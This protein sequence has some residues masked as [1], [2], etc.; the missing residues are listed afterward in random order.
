MR[1]RSTDANRLFSSSFFYLLALSLLVLLSRTSKE[2]SA[3][4]PEI[5]CELDSN[6]DSN[7]ENSIVTKCRAEWQ[8]TWA[9]IAPRASNPKKFSLLSGL[10]DV[11]EQ[12]EI[13]FNMT[14]V[15]GRSVFGFAVTI[16]PKCSSQV[17]CDATKTSITLQTPEAD[18][19]FTSKACSVQ[20][21]ARK[22]AF[23][24]PLNRNDR[25]VFSEVTSTLRCE[26]T[27]KPCSGSSMLVSV[28]FEAELA[29]PLK[30][31]SPPMSPVSPNAPP[32]PPSPPMPPGAFAPGGHGRKFFQILLVLVAI[33]CSLGYALALAVTRGRWSGFTE[34]CMRGDGKGR[35][36]CGLLFFWWWPR[37]WTEEDE[38]CLDAY[39]ED[40]EDDDEE[41]GRRRLLDGSDNGSSSSEEDEE[42]ESE[43]EEE[44][45]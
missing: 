10:A 9:P 26:N 17:G 4:V 44:D 25:E 38:R 15:K 24:A 27:L 33:Y 23:D 37:F 30:P 13:P 2:A 41:T 40:D 22:C 5:R 29:A 34:P 20:E 14:N 16:Q 32:P 12:R 31:P 42:E 43:E 28:D 11:G 45:D 6:S 21:T 39:Y 19:S 36:A 1:R 7:S 3:C 8:C 18:D 35:N